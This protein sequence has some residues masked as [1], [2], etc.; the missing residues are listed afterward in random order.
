MTA[1]VILAI[2]AVMVGSALEKVMGLSPKKYYIG[3]GAVLVLLLIL[4]LVLNL[5]S[6]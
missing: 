3:V 2:V 4:N 5:V 1:I 6:R